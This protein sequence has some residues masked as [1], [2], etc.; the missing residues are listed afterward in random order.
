VPITVHIVQRM[1][2][3]GIETLVLDLALV[4]ENIHVVSLEGETQDL[5]ARWQNLGVL[6]KR[7]IALNK[8]QGRSFKLLGLVARHL[9]KIKAKA[10]IMH[11]IGPLVYGGLAARLVGIKTRVHIEHD[12]W[13]YLNKRRRMVGQFLD[14]LVRPRKVAVSN[15][16]AKQVQFALKSKSID[17]IPNGVDMECFVPADKQA[18]RLLFN[19]PQGVILVGSVGRLVHVK[20]HDILVVAM[21]F[22]PTHIHLVLAGDG[23]Q[24]ATLQALAKEHGVS[25]RIYFLGNC[26]Q[27]ETLY[28]AF[29]VFCLPSRAEGFPRSLIEAQACD[30]RVIA[31]D[32]GGSREAVCP[33]TGHMV[34]AQNAEKL[35]KKIEYVLNLQI[36]A[37][38]RA[39][40]NPKFSFERT[41]EDYTKLGAIS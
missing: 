17:I 30:I 40:V 41:S 39:F 11:H 6:G 20:G 7:F 25:K 2:P 19:L 5:I 26:S 16:T 9:T 15:S 1:A 38:P 28:P 32:V 27:T 4:D 36:T 34:E 18:A 24:R 10:V 35:A 21:R 23:D 3:G 13:H 29:D 22:L 12:G 33:I 31:T 14:F 8:P 37:N